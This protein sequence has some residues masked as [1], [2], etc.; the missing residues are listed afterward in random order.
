MSA[1]ASTVSPFTCSGAMYAGVPTML[2][3]G[4]V[5]AD[6]SWMVQRRDGCRFAVE[7]LAEVRV[8]RVL[9]G[10]HLDGNRYFQARMRGAINDTHRSS[11]ELRL[12]RVLSEL[13]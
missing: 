13:S 9:L 3:V 6:D 2:L 7:W 11:P 12:D 10:Q 8:A 1:R 4:V 5:A